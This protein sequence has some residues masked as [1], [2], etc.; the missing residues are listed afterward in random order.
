MIITRRDLATI[1]IGAAATLAAPRIL[2]AEEPEI[3][4]GAPNA[5]TG[6]YG[7]ASQR[8]AQGL[9]VAVARINDMGGIKA[10]GGA[11]LRAVVADTSGENPAQAASVT[12]RMITEDKAVALVGCN[13]SAMTLSAQVE[14]ERARVPLIT[15]SYADQITQRGM[16][17]T[18]KLSR[19][20]SEIFG[21]GLTYAL[22]MMTARDGKR[23]TRL[24]VYTASDASSMA[25]GA[26][27]E[28]LAK[29]NNIEMVGR[30]AY[31][32]NV[33][34]ATPIIGSVLQ[35]RPELIMIS[36]A[37]DD[38]I[39]VV[40]ALRGAG[41]KVPIVSGGGAIASDSAGRSLGAA[42]NGL[43][44]TV[45]WNG[46]L[47]LPGVKDI[48][49]G[50]HKMFPNN[51]YPP[52]SEQLGTGYVAGMIFAEA[53]EKSAS[54]DPQKIRD[55]ISTHEFDMPVPGGKVAFD[56]KGLTKTSIPVMVGWTGGHLR[57]IW[58]KEFQTVSP[59]F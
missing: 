29:A 22:D 40:R 58:P 57:T 53:M 8:Y 5:L 34:D 1:G 4:I 42:A 20:G 26:A 23:P 2:R 13:V 28:K 24:A 51:P 39:F 25:V 43:I 10:L 3:V 52:A 54:R 48:V 50:Y 19:L 59:D 36:S 37:T 33:T 35:S 21:M 45:D 32:S 14:A 46:D 41:I 27:A 49:E 7:E 55:Y 17:Y 31:P 15:A 12:R 44:G 6:G 38:L 9:Q 11:K 16:Q 18:F 47:N 30:V 56:E